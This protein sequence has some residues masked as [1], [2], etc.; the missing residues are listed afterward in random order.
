M[1]LYN[2]DSMVSPFLQG[3][4]FVCMNVDEQSRKSK[5]GLGPGSSSDLR[6]GERPHRNR[7]PSSLPPVT[8]DFS[9]RR[10]GGS[11]K[12]VSHGGA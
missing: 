3:Y 11:E 1:I 4:R 8:N 6:Q 2:L 9:A 7:K 10:M 5:T 12:Y